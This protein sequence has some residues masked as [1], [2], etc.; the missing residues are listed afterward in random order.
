MINV[1]TIISILIDKH[2]LLSPADEK[3]FKR[4][5]FVVVM[6]KEH[7]INEDLLPKLKGFLQRSRDVIST[8]KGIVMSWLIK[9][10]KFIEANIYKC[11]FNTFVTRKSFDG[12]NKMNF[13][14]PVKF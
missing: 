4:R 5:R 11:N 7:K 6:M 3:P 1:L 12:F 10:F 9:F 13:F 2:L 8:F 14:F